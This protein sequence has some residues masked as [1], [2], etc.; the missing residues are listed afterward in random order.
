MTTTNN[1]PTSK[2]RPDGRRLNGRRATRRL[3]SQLLV[4]FFALLVVGA[5]GVGGWWVYGQVRTLFQP[6]E[7]TR[8]GVVVGTQDVTVQRGSITE[9]IIA[10]GT[11][12]A[13]RDVSLGYQVAR[14]EVTA[15]NVKAGDS[16]KKGQV[17]VELDVVA[18]EGAVAEARAELLDAQNALNALTTSTS[19]SPRLKAEVALR[20]AQAT[21]D[22]A[23]QTLADYDAGKGTLAESRATAATDLSDAQAALVALRDSTDRA[24]QIDRLQW[25]YNLAEVKHGPMVLIQN[26]SEKDQDTEWLLRN[27]MLDKLQ[28]LEVAKQQYQIDLR[29]AEEKVVT[30][31]RAVDSLDQQIAAGG[32]ALAREKLVVAVGT[33]DANVQRAAAQLAAVDETTVDVDLV[34]AQTDELKA[35]WNLADAEAALAEA[36]LV[37]PF[38]G[39]IDTVSVLTGAVVSSSAA[40]VTMLDPT[41]LYGLLRISDVDISRVQAGQEVQINFEALRNSQ[42]VKGAL[43]DIPLFG[44]YSNGLTYFE[45]PVSFNAGRLSLRVG[46]TMNC[47]IVVGGVT[48]VLLVPLIA[49]QTDQ[50]GTYCTVVQ[51]D[52]TE[53]RAVTTGASDGVSV[54]ITEGLAEGE[55]VRAPLQSPVR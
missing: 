51:G 34:T 29:A 16:V 4:V 45:V 43:G 31:Q 55:I 24:A 26:P 5:L 53:R 35:E 12:R 18:L 52:H 3:I 6:T 1:K 23:R 10:Y 48:D 21:L 8:T 44:T 41:S 22:A 9:S 13:S 20:D 32:E 33:A 2:Q 25:I 46:M 36:N 37:A 42:T 11:V 30:A 19:V 39:T 28:A 50:A 40:L 17:L 27:D 38:D 7:T 47:Q 14:G 54:E 49:V 15:V